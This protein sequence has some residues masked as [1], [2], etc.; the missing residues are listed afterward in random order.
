MHV[1]RPLLTLS[2]VVLMLGLG[3]G[4][5]SLYIDGRLSTGTLLLILFAVAALTAMVVA[6]TSRK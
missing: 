4:L 1:M 2:A 6:G 5:V 3:L